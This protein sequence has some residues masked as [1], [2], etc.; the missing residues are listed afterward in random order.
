MGPAKEAMCTTFILIYG[1]IHQHGDT[2]AP[3]TWHQRL[4]S[5]VRVMLVRGR[6]EGSTTGNTHRLYSGD[7]HGSEKVRLMNT[8]TSIAVVVILSEFISRLRRY[9]AVQTITANILTD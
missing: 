1:S 4:A 8:C 9:A 3:A 7:R 2:G 5:P 6:V